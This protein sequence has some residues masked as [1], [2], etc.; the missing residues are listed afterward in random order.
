MQFLCCAHI[1]SGRLVFTHS[2]YLNWT[3][4]HPDFGA[5]D[6]VAVEEAEIQWLEENIR[7]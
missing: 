1:Q 5:Y 3:G 6:V 2:M 4:K 7:M